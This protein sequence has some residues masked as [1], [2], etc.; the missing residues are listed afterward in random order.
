LGNAVNALYWGPG[1]VFLDVP[2]G[3]EWAWW[4]QRIARSESWSRGIAYSVTARTVEHGLEQAEHDRQAYLEHVLGD[5]RELCR[6]RLATCRLA[7]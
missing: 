4:R 2:T 5:T 3:A 6:N 7:E 1:R